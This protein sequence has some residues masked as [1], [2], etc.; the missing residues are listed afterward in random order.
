[1]QHFSTRLLR[2]AGLLSRLNIVAHNVVGGRRYRVPL[3]AGLNEGLLHLSPGFKTAL[4]EYISSITDVTHFVDIGANFGQTMLE[5]SAWKPCINYFGFE[6][7]PIT[8][9][10]LQ[11]V[12]RENRLSVELFPWACS[13]ESRPVKLFA[14]SAVDA[15]AS[16]MPETRPGLYN[17]VKGKWICGFPLDLVA[18]ELS[19]PKNFVLKID[20]EG[21]ELHVLQ[22]AKQTIDTHRPFIICEVLHAHN[23]DTLATNDDHKRKIQ[24][25]L[26][27]RGYSIYQCEL[28]S[29]PGEK[30]T[31]L[32]PVDQFPKSRIYRDCPETCDFL[33][34]PSELEA[35]VR[36]ST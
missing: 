12:A 8:F 21:A 36:R 33:F 35:K 2:R 29:G 31:K 28:S 7:N 3:V 4:L 11:K 20:V 9:S 17:G 10:I 34:L 30:L 32:S 18:G 25:F 16:I 1:M 14:V 22:G 24:A 23:H 13:S 26:Q 6:P 27:E 15:G 5:V 19:L